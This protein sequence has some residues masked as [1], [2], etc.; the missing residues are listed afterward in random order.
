MNCPMN[1]RRNVRQSA[2]AV[3]LLVGTAPTLGAGHPS[4]LA[5][6]QAHATSREHDANQN[7][8]SEV[9]W[10]K[11]TEACGPYSLYILL[12]LLGH[13]ADFAQLLDSFQYTNRG[14]DML[15]LKEVSDRQGCPCVVAQ[16]APEELNSNQLPMIVLLRPPVGGK[17]HFSVLTAVTDKTYDIIDGTTGERVSLTHD[18]FRR[19]W[20]GYALYPITHSQ[21]R[22]F[23]IGLIATSVVAMLCW[24]YPA[25]GRSSKAA[26]GSALTT[27]PMVSTQPATL[28]PTNSLAG[29]RID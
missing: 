16:M 10:A 15:Q 25:R 19:L 22:L 7:D 18:G 24:F 6:N 28:C 3:A 5:D 21:E 9:S 27:S 11:Q 13:D 23:L 1:P 20:T 14:V 26:P 12:R 4:T 2:I 29:H 8:V 17:G